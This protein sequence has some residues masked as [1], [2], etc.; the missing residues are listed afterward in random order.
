[1]QNQC[2]DLTLKMMTYKSGKF[3][4][5][6]KCDVST[7]NPLVAEATLRY[8][9][10]ADLPILPDLA[11]RLDQ[12]LIRR[13]I[14]GTAA[15]EGNPLSEDQ[16]GEVLSKG[17]STELENRAT[18]EIRNLRIAYGQLLTSE[19]P[20]SD[21]GKKKGDRFLELTEEYIRQ[22]HKIITHGIDYNLNE[23][24]SYRNHKVEVGDKGHGGKY[25][26][27]K[28]LDDIKSIMEAFIG[29]I[30][31]E[32]FQSTIHPF[33]RAALAH[34]YFGVIHPFADGNGRTARFI[35]A[36]ILSKAGFK[37]IPN[38]LSN[39]YYRHMDEYYIAFRQAETDKDDDITT[40][41]TFIL[42]GII[43]SLKEI[44]T[45]IVDYIRLFSLRDYYKFLRGTRRI[46]RR[47]YGLLDLVSEIHDPIDLNGLYSK[48]PYNLLY[49]NKVSK[50]TA[51]RDLKKLA[52]MSL[53]TK[54][55]AG[56]VCNF[57][58][59]G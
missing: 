54:T 51:R 3:V 16:V 28:V 9:S 34:Y 13:S 56:Y 2:Q 24:G 14:H 59:L 4:F 49:H 39:Y 18:R 27:P 36:A 40:F 48:S 11:S 15:I 1:M 44:R 31:A 12:E 55:D 58:K 8:E 32:A 6:G 22:V 37:Y 52:G 21:A 7:I 25:V 33:V 23:P 41:I 53:L 19:W 57:R 45:K 42:N 29:W 47:Q 10:I 5:S 35:E 38:M 20:E 46:T 17:A 30:N 26:P 50:D 43:E